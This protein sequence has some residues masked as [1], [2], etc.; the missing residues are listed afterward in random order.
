VDHRTDVYSLG[1]TLYELLTLE[2][3]FSGQDRR[4]LLRQIL[5]EEPRPPRQVNRG[6]PVELETIVLKAL[7]KAPEER[8]ATA[9]EMAADL[10]RFLDEQPILA[11]RPSLVERARKWMR[12]HPSVVGTAVVLLLFVA[13]ALG[14]T[15]TLVAQEQ[16]RT[17]EAYA[18]E[19]ERA[20]EAEKRLQ[21]AQRVADDLIRLAEDEVPDDDPRLQG[22][23]KRLLE[24]GLDYYQEFIEQRR[25]DPDAQ[26]RLENTRDRVEK[27]IADLAVLQGIG[28][29]VLLKNRAVLDALEASAKQRED[30][31]E[32][33]RRQAEQSRTVAEE[34]PSLPPEQWRQG[35]L[36]DAHANEAAIQSILSRKQLRRLRQIA[37][38]VQGLDAFGEPEVLA[39]L[40]L[41]PEQ[42]DR[43]RGIKEEV[44]RG[45]WP[46]RG[47]GRPGRGMVDRRSLEESRDRRG[48]QHPRG[49]FPGPPRGPKKRDEQ[50]RQQVQEQQRKLKAAFEKSLAVLTKEQAKRWQKLTG[51]P[52]KGPITFHP[53]GGPCHVGPR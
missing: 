33:L 34:G 43:L 41:S 27:I 31:K 19:R 12:R 8:Y 52:F 14:V 22:L 28:R 49:R 39:A 45:R 47:P 42:R 35:F 5:E 24:V 6:I 25:D 9:A 20:D 11:R 38:Q 16:A 37:I 30:V 7:A 40:R 23:R 4:A 29:L 46:G 51:E 2:P 10:R 18:Q 48:K 17:K 26:A 21:M 13:V 50:F 53:H 32:V 1:A 36:E 44:M 3:I 15:T